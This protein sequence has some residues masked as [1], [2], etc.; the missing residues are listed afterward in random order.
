[1]AAKFHGVDFYNIDGLLSEEERAIRDTVRDWVDE[2]LMPVIGEAY[3]AGKLPT[4]L[5]PGMAELGLFG[6]NL[7]QQYGCAG[8][9][10]VAHGSI[11]QRLERGH[12]RWRAL[13]PVH[14]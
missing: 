11:M 3:V 6:A 5:L 1:M 14:G 13:A 9:N 12:A 10:Q 7:P 4:Q 8:L 2:N